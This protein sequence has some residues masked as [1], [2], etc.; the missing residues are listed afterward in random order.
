MATKWD[1]SRHGTRMVKQDLIMKQ[2]TDVIMATLVKKTV[3][4]RSKVVG[5][6]LLLSLA[7]N[8]SHETKVPYYNDAAFTPL[9]INKQ[10]AKGIHKIET[11]HVVNQKGKIITNENLK[12]KVTLVNFFFTTCQGICPKMMHTMKMVQ[13]NFK[14]NKEVSFISY[15]VTPDKDDIRKLSTYAED[16]N[17]PVKQWNL[18]TGNKA[19]IYKLARESYFI[20]EEPGLSKNLKQ[21]L[22]TE[23]FVL[24]DY[25]GHIRGLYN[26]T[27]EA[28][29]PR[30]TEDI[31]A[32]L[33]TE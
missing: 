12:G 20:E 31:Q 14:N 4:R 30:I 21:F 16:N 17:I 2:E 28:E 27:L 10:K 15:S 19:E 9:W 18:V 11:F 23:N 7:C 25:E 3:S 26:G 6:L 33:I 13:E 1:C 29:V 24:I 22:H 8:S 32:L 5:I